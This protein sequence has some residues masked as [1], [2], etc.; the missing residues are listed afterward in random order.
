MIMELN[1]KFIRI[2]LFFLFF[3]FLPL[4]A[5]CQQDEENRSDSLRKSFVPKDTVRPFTPLR[6]HGSVSLLK[7]LKHRKINKSD[8]QFDNY[9]NI[10]EILNAHIN[11]Y[12]LFLGAPGLFNNFAMFGASPNDN[13]VRLNGRT[14]SDF[15]YGSINL[16]QYSP[17]FMENFEI[18]RGSDAIIF[19]D[20]ASGFLLNIQQPVYNTAKPYTKLWYAQAGNDFTGADGVYSQ[21][22]MKNWNMTLGFRRLS[23]GGRFA[24]TEM[25]AWNLR[26]ALR[27][28]ISP[29]TNL[30][31]TEV[32]VNHGN[33]TNGGNSII[34]SADIFDELQAIPV[35]ETM[36]ERVFRHDLTSTLSTYLN[37]DSN[38]ALSLNAY[39]S[40]SEWNR[41]RPLYSTATGDSGTEKIVYYERQF[42]VNGKFEQEILNF[43]TLRLGGEFEKLNIDKNDFSD[44]YDGIRTALFSHAQI[45]VSSFNLSGGLRYSNLGNHNYLNIGAKAQIDLFKDL[46]LSVDISRAERFPSLSEGLSLKNEKSYLAFADVSFNRNE[47]SFGFSLFYR[48]I[49]D[50]ILTQIFN[51]QKDSLTS[52]LI[53]SA[54]NGSDRI[55]AG[56][57]LN[58]G[59]RIFRHILFDFR[60][61]C[62][63]L[64][65]TN[66]FDDMR[67]PLLMGGF[68]SYYEIVK[69]KSILNL[70]I[71]V[72]LTSKFKGEI[73]YPQT[74][75]YILNNAE[76]TFYFDN[77]DIFASARLGNAFVRLAYENVFYRNYYYV[78]YYPAYSGNLR[79]SVSWAFLD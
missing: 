49:E 28:N 73:F 43:F 78:P 39:V 69:G 76:S 27:W 61:Q 63:F 13:S 41:N 31:L 52:L 22:F 20:N 14:I 29:L 46:S 74:R 19:S 45:E 3:A 42:G 57:A 9:N 38:S 58:G 7:G 6:L 60:A 64:S 37:S 71:N 5:F 51:I 23:S 67:F 17:E 72:N 59:F 48:R 75:T 1:M 50:P 54:Y 77:F 8:I 44:A 55:V 32:F 40:Y 4:A 47:T 66:G 25:D 65:R 15:Q 26:A 35:F 53:P 30:S 24:N 18:L 79:L 36:T 62:H 10:S 21:N 12:P 33:G 34:N 56:A 68:K 70:G 11:A 2:L 16:E